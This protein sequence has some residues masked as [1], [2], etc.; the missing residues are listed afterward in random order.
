MKGFKVESLIQ[1]AGLGI[2]AG[3]PQRLQQRSR[4]R[5]HHSELAAGLEEEKSFLHELLDL[6]RAACRP[7]PAVCCVLPGCH[8]LL[9]CFPKFRLF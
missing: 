7:V 5:S 8:Y 2:E 1:R 9:D 3:L 6:L 4:S